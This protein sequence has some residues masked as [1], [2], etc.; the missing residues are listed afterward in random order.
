MNTAKTYIPQ[1]L[2]ITEIEWEPLI[3][4]IVQANRSLARYDGVLSG[5]P[6]PRVLLSPLTTREA[7]LSSR[8]EGTRATLG[9][10]LRFEAGD[11]ESEPGKRHDIQEIINYRRALRL[12]EKEL[13]TRP[14]NLN[15]LLKLHATLLDSV[16]G[17]DKARGSF[18]IIQNWIGSTN[19]T[20]DQ[21]QF[22]PPD[23][24]LVPEYMD[25]WEKYYHS[26][27][28]DALVQLAVVHAQFEIIHP[29]ID[30]NGRLGRMLVPIFLFEKQILSEPVFYLSSY[31]E[32]HREAY[33]EALR[34]LCQPGAWNRWI[35]FFLNALINQASENETKARQVITL[36]ELLK[37]DVSKSIH[38]RYV[39]PL[40][41]KMFDFPIFQVSSLH[42]P[43]QPSR[44]TLLTMINKLV[45]AGILVVIREGA[46][47]RGQ[48][49][50]FQELLS[51]C[52]G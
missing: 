38:S 30:G 24:L 6:N 25:N 18:R 21:A 8:I 44:P 50:V 34:D 41:D 33:T 17:Q 19:S 46:G 42:F 15:L 5:V 48:V 10:V 1:K 13:E 45:D 4:L 37:S 12:A 27:R 7:V 26:E 9:E 31:L 47:R 43:V 11:E 51:I 23:P 49:L 39:I 32:Q 35:T 20:I 22:V 2:P 40:L 52:E 29:F 3:P 16:R 14:F 36:Y 28:P